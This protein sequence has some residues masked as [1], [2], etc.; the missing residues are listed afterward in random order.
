MHFIDDRALP[1]CAGRPILT[2]SERGIDDA[3]FGHKRSAVAL[4]K[5]LST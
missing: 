5:E 4:V 1:G 3:A 2:P